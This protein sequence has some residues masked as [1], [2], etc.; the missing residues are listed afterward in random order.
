MSE[1]SELRLLSLA[2]LAGLCWNG[3]RV[4]EVPFEV[5]RQR[6]SRQSAQAQYE[7]ERG[8]ETTLVTIHA[9]R[10]PTGGYTV[11][12]RKVERDGARC[13][14]HYAVVPPPEDAM[15][16][17]VITYPA[18]AVRIAAACEDVTVEPPLPR[19]APGAA[20]ERLQ[21]E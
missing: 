20:R 19:A 9:G 15:V 10:K 21:K 1:A 11:K 13:T 6:P 7:V 2:L 5:I 18:V 8:G 17:Q 12:V 16:P 4:E 14:V 3:F